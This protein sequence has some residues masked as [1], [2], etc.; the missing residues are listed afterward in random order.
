MKSIVVIGGGITGLTTLYYLQ[1]IKKEKQLD[2]KLTLIEKNQ[3]L[4]GKINSE[5]KN[6]FVMETGAD[7]IVTRYEEVT[8][9]LNDLKLDNEMVYNSTGV[10]YIYTKGQLHKI[11][12]DTVFG[13][14]TSIESLFSSTLISDE[15]K[16]A[17]L[18]DLETKNERFTKESS[19]ASF[20]NY[21]LGEELVE[22]QIA[23]V[24]S[25][26][27]SGNLDKLTLA[28]T[29]PYLLDYKND[30]GSIIKGLG[31]NKAKFQ[32]SGK[33]KFV[34]FKEGLST[35]IDRLEI[36]L[37]DVTIIKGDEVTSISKVDKK[38]DVQLSND[39]TITSDFVVLA[40]PHQVAQHLLN[41]KELDETFNQFKNSSLTSIYLGFDI[42]DD[43]LPADG[44]GFIVAE[45]SDL[46]CDACTWTSKKWQHTSS[47]HQVLLR[48]FYKSTNPNYDQIKNLNQYKLTEFAL[49]DIEKSLGFHSKPSVVEVTKWNDLMPNYHLGHNKAVQSI[50][51]QLNDHYPNIRLAGSS[52]YGVGIG[53][54][55]K[56]GEDVA[57]WVT[58]QL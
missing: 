21:F 54:C 2:L 22:Q 52:Y 5:T 45:D 43:E 9:L 25:G 49:K 50:K 15:G 55:I 7:S 3:Y 42:P 47:Q 53:A 40:T 58:E 1:K 8:R 19:V 20:L 44:T 39:N 10:S 41:N 33:G 4:G 35:L 48:L 30:Y 14:P 13:I 24:L 23:P 11:P 37:E 56:N 17:A 12:E 38:Y 36:S 29:L 51:N 26:V 46:H 34:S 16:Q 31:E 28:S 27:Y 6:G 32:S 57:L 18:R